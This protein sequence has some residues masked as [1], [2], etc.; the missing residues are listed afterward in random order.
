MKTEVKQVLEAFSEVFKSIHQRSYHKLGNKNLYPG[1]PKLLVLIK[2]HEGITQKELSEKNFVKPSTI[3]GMLNKLEANKLVTRVPDEDDKR[4]M[5]IYLTPEGQHL[6][7]Q[8]EK[9]MMSMTEQLFEGFSDE[10]LR[11]FVTLAEKLRDNVR[12]NEK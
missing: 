11:I 7:E 3:T 1:Q 8:G 2:S 12:N 10:E 5:R 9:F 4:M 6:A